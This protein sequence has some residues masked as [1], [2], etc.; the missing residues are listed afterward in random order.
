MNQKKLKIIIIS[1]LV[2]VVGLTGLYIYRMKTRNAVE[3]L[4]ENK[5]LINV[6]IA[7][8]NVYKDNKHTFYCIVS[9]N[10]ENNRIGVTFLPP[11]LKVDLS[12]DGDDLVRLDEVDIRDFEKLS[13]FISRNMKIRVPF[14]AILYAPDVSRIIDLAEGV[15]LYILDQVKGIDGL[16]RGLNYFDGK[17]VSQYI[18][19]SDDN[20]I[21]KRYDRVQDI[22]FTMY[23]NRTDYQ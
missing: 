14:Y 11:S 13:S 2:S 5:L 20:S 8:T 3:L 19:Y 16:T 22:M 1:I 21:Y 12:G 9:I 4:A 6:L 18:N 15:N 17:K 23:Y 10:P 7:G